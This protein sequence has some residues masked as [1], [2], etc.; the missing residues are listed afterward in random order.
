MRSTSTSALRQSGV[1]GIPV[2]KTQSI[3]LLA[4]QHR[5]SQFLQ[6]RTWICCEASFQIIRGGVKYNSNGYAISLL[7]VYSVWCSVFLKDAPYS[8]KLPNVCWKGCWNMNVNH[9]L[10]AW[11]PDSFKL[12]KNICMTYPTKCINQVLSVVRISSMMMFTA[13][14]RWSE[15]LS[16]SRNISCRQLWLSS[17]ARTKSNWFRWLWLWI[18]IHTKSLGIPRTP[19]Y[20]S[21]QNPVRHAMQ[22]A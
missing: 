8:W 3:A 14:P 20:P 1:L 7:S 17:V 5:W 9:H 19:K 10:W 4:V 2:L 15:Q 18:I 13:R 12:L 6:G 22:P 21:A 16:F 11:Y